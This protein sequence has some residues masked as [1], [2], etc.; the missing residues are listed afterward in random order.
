MPQPQRRR[1]DVREYYRM[2]ESRI[3]SPGE[4]VELIGGEIVEMGPI[5]SR[6]AACVNGLTELLVR[7][8]GE[9]AMIAVQN[10]V[11]ISDLSEPQ[12]DI[13]ALRRRPDR[14]A[15][16]HPGPDDVL[17]LIEVADASLPVDAGV[18]A[19]L[20]AMAGIADYWIVDL[21]AGEVRVY[22]D[23]G[24][25]GYQSITT[26]TPG[27]TVRPLALPALEIAVDDIVP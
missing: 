12:P 19:T 18:K 14:Y 15:E 6:H 5:G 13:A 9:A 25:D 17:L 16:A 21:E 7:G 22:R 3:L 10:P 27:E 11:R 24:Q 4:R 2:A 20:Y 23:P 26:H 8:A 1:F